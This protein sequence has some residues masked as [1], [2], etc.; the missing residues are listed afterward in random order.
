MPGWCCLQPGMISVPWTRICPTFG[1]FLAP[2]FF[3]SLAK[4]QLAMN[5]FPASATLWA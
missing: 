2:S 3:E 4:L 5:Q 1:Y